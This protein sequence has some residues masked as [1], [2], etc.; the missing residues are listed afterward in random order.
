MIA[1][2]PAIRWHLLERHFAEQDPRRTQLQA[3]RLALEQ[4][5]EAE[6]LAGWIDLVGPFRRAE[7]DESRKLRESCA[8]LS[9]RIAQRNQ[10]A[11]F[12]TRLFGHMKMDAALFAEASDLLQ[13][14]QA[15]PE[16]D[17]VQEAL[18]ILQA[19]LLAHLLPE[20]AG[21]PR[22]LVLMVRDQPELAPLAKQLL[23][24]SSDPEQIR[25]W[26]PTWLERWPGLEKRP[27]RR[28]LLEN[29]SVPTAF[30]DSLARLQTQAASND[31]TEDATVLRK[32]FLELY[33][34]GS[35]SDFSEGRDWLQRLYRCLTQELRV[36]LWPEL[37]AELQPV[38]EKVPPEAVEWD[39]QGTAPLGQATVTQWGEAPRVRLRVTAELAELVALPTEKLG[40]NFRELQLKIRKSATQPRAASGLID[41]LRATFFSETRDQPTEAL[42]Q[43]A[44]HAWK[45]NSDAVAW[46][47]F[48]QKHNWMGRLYPD[49]DPAVAWPAA[50]P[51]GTGVTTRWNKAEPG[52][53][54][55]VTHFALDPQRAQCVLS[56]GPADGYPALSAAQKLRELC[57]ESAT[58]RQLERL[59][60]Q[61]LLG[62]VDHVQ[63]QRDTLKTLVREWG[64]LEVAAWQ[65]RHAPLSD[66]ARSLGCTL[67][68]KAWSPT[69]QSEGVRTETAF[70]DSPAGTLLAIQGAVQLPG[71][72]NS[73]GVLRFSLGP[74]PAGYVEL[75]AVLPTGPLA[76]FLRRLPEG[77]DMRNKAAIQEG[78]REWIVEFY[79]KTRE[80]PI[81]ETAER[82]LATLLEALELETFSPEPGSKRDPNWPCVDDTGRS[83]DGGGTR[84]ERTYH[85]GLKYRG[86]LCVSPLVVVR[87][88]N[89][90]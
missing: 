49:V 3:V 65:H 60:E 70:A 17:V 53:V 86:Q 5:R 84:I 63:A 54:L 10:N 56:L 30:S 42:Q 1:P 47:R 25:A 80:H 2:A 51:L 89:S 13:R 83:L 67:W 75:L 23:R 45:G 16:E 88:G 6:A 14:C 77:I 4:G 34:R 38:W 12:V 59:F 24:A 40:K 90:A 61:V 7:S 22:W 8:E 21:R 19:D 74:A 72:E 71:E 36:A 81:P 68:P 37:D 69:E 32:E 29:V 43:L 33:A 41:K 64:V 15:T 73:H 55:E 62:G 44:L 9:G 46:V 79:C 82:P 39:T 48:F 35:G 50:T 52:R 26:L 87:G 58:A 57:P 11:H 20:S 27:L 85:P 76:E 31:E 18:A 66:L 78:I 28:L